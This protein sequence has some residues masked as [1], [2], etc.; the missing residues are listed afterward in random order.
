MAGIYVGSPL[1]VFD[2]PQLYQKPPASVLLS[3]LTQLAIVPSSFS[4]KQANT[5]LDVDEAGLTGYLTRIIAS[6]LAWIS[7]DTEREEIWEAASQRL[8]ERS[9]RM[10]MASISRVFTIRDF[11]VKKDGKAQKYIHIRLT[12]PSLTDDNIGHKTWSGSFLL[13]KRLAHMMAKH[14]PSLV[15]P[16]S[17][18][19][20]HLKAIGVPDTADQADVSSSA[21]GLEAFH[22]L[23]PLP[24]PTN[25][26]S[27][28]TRGNTLS[29][30][31]ETSVLELGAGTGLTGIAAAALFKDA[32]VH[33][34]DLP[35]IIPNLMA[36]VK[37]NSHL[38]V[39]SPTAAVLDWSKLPEKV[40][41]QDQYDCILAA[42]S[43]YDPRHPDWLTSAVALFLK[44]QKTARVMVELPFRDMGLSYHDLL[45]E[46]M[47]GKG[48]VVL[49]EGEELGWD[50]WEGSCN[51]KM[52]VKCWWSVWSW[53]DEEM[54]SADCGKQLL[55][56]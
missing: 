23:S 19:C 35:S 36:N 10:A 38:F 39:A 2:L 34:T 37:S 26:S 56:E 7:S 22:R 50:D 53:A 3:V 55:E 11:A 18:R 9:G 42:D 12:E 13:A 51:E 1:T 14:F 52:A 54:I 48:L 30:L 29:P 16:P 17:P 43:L 32:T 28:G 5:S 25:P 33:L 6:P 20:S 21:V 24:S 8:S 40:A 41:P 15:P 31:P 49:E 4:S 46:E 44:R 47:T 45:R 27:T